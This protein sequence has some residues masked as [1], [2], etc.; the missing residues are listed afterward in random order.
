LINQ[1]GL[2]RKQKNSVGKHQVLGTSSVRNFK[3]EDRSIFRSHEIATNSFKTEKGD[4][5]MNAL[6]NHI[7]E[8]VLIDNLFTGYYVGQHVI[9]IR[10]NANIALPQYL[11][12]ALNSRFVQQQLKLRT[13]GT[14][15]ATISMKRIE[16]V[17]IPVPELELQV[18]LINDYNNILEEIIHKESDLEK[19]KAKLN[20][21]LDNL[22]LIS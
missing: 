5:L 22:T 16:D 11:L 10:P 17:F 3:I 2:A 19:S 13:A 4:I 18:K 20:G 12:L 7:G 8:S 14:V 1:Q 9:C 6:G 21:L 15:M